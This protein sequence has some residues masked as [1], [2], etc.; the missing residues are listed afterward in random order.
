MMRYRLGDKQ[1]AIAACLQAAALYL[2]Q[3]KAKE[4]Q[5]VLKMLQKLQE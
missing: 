5:Y 2:K 3:G 4:H 1:G